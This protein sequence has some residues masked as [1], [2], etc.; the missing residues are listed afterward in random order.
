MVSNSLFSLL[1]FMEPWVVWLSRLVSFLF[2]YKLV[3]RV[4]NYTSIIIQVLHY[5]QSPILFYK[6]K[7]LKSYLHENLLREKLPSYNNYVE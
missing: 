7:C 4:F 6:S 1:V 2:V 5:N 3:S